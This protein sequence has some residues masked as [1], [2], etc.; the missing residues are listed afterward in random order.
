MTVVIG[1]DPGE[2]T[3]LFVLHVERPADSVAIQVL[4]ASAVL[5]IVVA[6]LDTHRMDLVAP[7][8]AIEEFVVSNRAARSATP[9]AG[10]QTRELI[11]ALMAID[12]N[13]VLRPA[14]TVKKWA[15]DHR[16]LEAGLLERT[17]G[18]HHARDAC[19]HALFAAVSVRLMRDPLAPK[20][21][22]Q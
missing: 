13:L 11:G 12:A 7:I 5:P 8:V 3:G 16:L 21:T 6:L 14:V 22:A 19:R 15:T 2:T 17:K 20:E 9:K 18:M 10:K 4:G 1:I